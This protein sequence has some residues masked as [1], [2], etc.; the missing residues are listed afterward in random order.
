MDPQLISHNIILHRIR[1]ILVFF[2]V[3]LSAFS[4]HPIVGEGSSAS[5]TI[6]TMLY[7]LAIGAFILSFDRGGFLREKI[8]RAWAVVLIL[9]LLQSLILSG[10]GLGED[11]WS[12]FTSL[13]IAL[14]AVV[15]GYSS[16]LSTQEV[17]WFLLLYGI[18]LSIS[19]IAQIYSNFGGFVIQQLYAKF[20]KNSF[21]AMIGVF[22]VAAT[23]ISIKLKKKE[24]IAL[25]VLILINLLILITIRAR[26]AMLS[27]F[28]FYIAYFIFA[29]YKNRYRPVQIIASF[30]ILLIAVALF[31]VFFT[32]AMLN[33]MN[34]IYDSFFINVENGGDITSGR[35]ERNII[36][37]QSF[38]DN[39][40]FGLLG[41]DNE[42]PWVHNYP[43]LILSSYGLIGGVLLLFFYFYLLSWIGKIILKYKRKEEEKKVGYYCV[44]YLFII[45]M[46]EPTFPYVPGT[47]VIF[48][49]ILLGWSIRNI[50]RRIV[51]YSDN[52]KTIILPKN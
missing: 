2:V 3:L 22:V 24:K 16:R 7:I 46:A 18:V 52:K 37:F 47:A 17:V 20:S 42:I 1:R 33:A 30:T 5:S 10:I 9:L 48:A 45:S 36:A 28:L 34:Y 8:L 40:L 4:Y 50:P 49:F 25:A 44:A 19:G 35:S 26:A 41:S 14:I 38:L 21:G 31:A 51:L 11:F 39:P 15:I 12:D 6:R 32:N 43:L 13:S 29:L 23:I 27:V